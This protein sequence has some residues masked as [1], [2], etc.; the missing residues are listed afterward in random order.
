MSLMRVDLRPLPPSLRVVIL[1]MPSTLPFSSR[2]SP[3]AMRRSS[4]VWRSVGPIAASTSWTSPGMSATWLHAKRSTSSEG[5]LPSTA[6][7]LVGPAMVVVAATLSLKASSASTAPAST[8]SRVSSPAMAPESGWNSTSRRSSARVGALGFFIGGSFPCM[9][10][11]VEN[12]RVAL[13]V[14]G[15]CNVEDRA[16]GRWFASVKI[17][18]VVAGCH[19]F[20]QSPAVPSANAVRALSASIGLTTTWVEPVDLMRPRAG[21]P[22]LS[23]LGRRTERATLEQV[24]AGAQGGKSGVVVVRG[25]AGIGK[26]ALL[27]YAHAAATTLG[28]RTESAAGVESETQFAFAGLHQLCAPL[29]D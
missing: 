27:E 19:G 16:S 29:L 22:R 28:S 14:A 6:S 20:I 7:T 21:T 13:I 9:S 26:S 12:G 3:R 2:I 8:W 4:R 15:Q 23:L 18:Y 5:A 25:E 17:T 11:S 10:R 24:L 1:S